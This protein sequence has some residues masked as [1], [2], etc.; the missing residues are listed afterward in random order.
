[1]KT[2]SRYELTPHYRC[3][4]VCDEMDPDDDGSW[5]KFE[6]Y[7][8]AEIATA[9]IM[10]DMAWRIVTARAEGREEGIAA[11]RADEAEIRAMRSPFGPGGR[12]S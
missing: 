6:D 5:V 4:D 1:M 3:G 10:A 11:A 12:S 8:R 7:E 2:V 9:K